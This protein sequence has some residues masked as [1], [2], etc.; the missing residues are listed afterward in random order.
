LNNLIAFATDGAPA[1]TDLRK[2]FA[3]YFKKV[4][5]RCVF[6]NCM[7]L[8][9]M[10]GLT[11]LKDN[12]EEL[13]YLSF[14]IYSLCSFMIDLAKKIAIFEILQESQGPK[15]RIIKPSD[16][17]WLSNYIANNRV[18]QTFPEI[19]SLLKEYSNKYSSANGLKNS[20][21]QLRNI[22]LL[23]GFPDVR[24][25]IE[26]LSLKFQKKSC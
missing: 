10:L 17:R 16:I 24:T 22:L 15:L 8:R 11:S 1:M 3:F 12:D 14:T 7:S 18:L 23:C 9:Y 25:I 4:V 21:P 2:G 19:I 13:Q 20:L 26:D 6:V 5:K